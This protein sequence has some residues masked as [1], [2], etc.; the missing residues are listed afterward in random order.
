[1]FEPAEKTPHLRVCRGSPGASSVARPLISLLPRLSPAAALAQV[2][3]KL[4][5]RYEVLRG[6]G[7]KAQA[8]PK[9][10]SSTRTIYRRGRMAP[11]RLGLETS[12]FSLS[13][14]VLAPRMS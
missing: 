13:R 5:R 9:L 10:A 8:R 12:T 11:L 4:I 6:P 2:V 14:A 1:M 7:M 3:A